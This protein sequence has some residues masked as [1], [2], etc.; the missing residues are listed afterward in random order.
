MADTQQSQT[1][2]AKRTKLVNVKIYNI[3]TIK[4]K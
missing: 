1:Y 2:N 4:I 3:K